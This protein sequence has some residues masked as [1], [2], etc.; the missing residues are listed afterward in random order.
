MTQLSCNLVLSKHCTQLHCKRQGGD[1]DGYSSPPSRMTVTRKTCK[2]PRDLHLFLCSSESSPLLSS[3]AL[4]QTSR[5]LSMDT[6]NYDDSYPSWGRA[7][8]HD[9]SPC[10]SRTGYNLKFINLGEYMDSLNLQIK[11]SF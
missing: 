5:Y 1:Q 3:P 8:W 11:F 2:L 7:K 10:S 9:I 4:Q 6:L